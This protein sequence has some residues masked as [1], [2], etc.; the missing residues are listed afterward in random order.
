MTKKTIMELLRETNEK[1]E[2]EG[3]YYDMNRLFSRAMDAANDL[4]FE[5]IEQHVAVHTLDALE[6][7][8]N[9]LESNAN[10]K[11]AKGNQTQIKDNITYSEFFEEFNKKTDYH[12]CTSDRGG[13]DI[14]AGEGSL[15]AHFSPE[16]RAWL[17]RESVFDANGLALME[18]LAATPP[19]LRGEID[20]D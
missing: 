6:R 10:Q 16:Y 17:F 14:V 11:Q 20:N 12:A 13:A 18:K 4:H 2:A 15:K 19:E 9:A 3:H 8:A 7:I 1:A 5:S